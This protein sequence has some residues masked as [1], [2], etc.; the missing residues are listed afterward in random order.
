MSR[1]SNVVLSLIGVVLAILFAIAAIWGPGF[2]RKSKALVEPIVEITRSEERLAELDAELPFTEPVDG[3]VDDARFQAFL[4]VRRTL[5]PHYREWEDLERTLEGGE[6]N[7]EA[8]L[9]ALEGVREL[10]EVQIDTLRTAGMSPAEFIWLED[11]AYENW[12]A[13][14]SHRVEESIGDAA[15]REATAADLQLLAELERRHGS[16]AALRSLGDHLRGRLEALENP[17]APTV[18]GVAPE[19]S[20]LFWAHRK[21]LSEL[22]LRAYSEMHRII[23]GSDNVNIQIDAGD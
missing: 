20:E 19:T 3:V 11:L 8:A 21:E 6:E 9:E 7:W 22:D 1:T 12:F 14:V 5:L 17:G 4:D 15:V 23:R 16:S 2:Y 18:E 13:A 10:M